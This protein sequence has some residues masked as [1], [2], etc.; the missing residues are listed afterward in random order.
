MKENEFKD[1][2]HSQ[3]EEIRRYCKIK[4]MEC[5]ENFE[6]EYAFEWIEKYSKEFLKKWEKIRSGSL[7]D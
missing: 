6:N 2:M 7:S 5:P 4:K 3:L 1:F